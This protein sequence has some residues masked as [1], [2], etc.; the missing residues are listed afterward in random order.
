MF[1]GAV[2]MAQMV[3]GITTIGNTYMG[4]KGSLNRQKILGLLAQVKMFMLVVMA[5]TLHLVIA[6]KL[7]ILESRMTPILR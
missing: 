5:I 4:M 7:S 3:N 6:S 2:D 1:W